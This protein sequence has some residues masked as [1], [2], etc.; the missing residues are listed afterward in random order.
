V[1]ALR[2]ATGEPC[3]ACGASSVVDQDEFLLDQWDRDPIA[4]RWA[5]TQPVS[6]YRRE[7]AR[8]W[9]PRFAAA[10]H[11]DQAGWPCPE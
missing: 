3:L 7:S 9:M 2:H 5:L 10:C 4:V 11:G 6:R 1:K 8:A